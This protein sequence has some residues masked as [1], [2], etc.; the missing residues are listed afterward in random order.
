MEQA[1]A[2]ARA[3]A[4][5]GPQAPPPPDDPRTAVRNATRQAIQDAIRDMQG[6]PGIPTIGQPPRNSRPDV[7]QGAIQFASMFFIMIAVIALGVPIVRAL[8]RRFDRKTEN[9]KLGGA[10]MEHQLRQL[11]DSVDSMAIEIERI[12]ES[13]RFTSKLMAERAASVPLL[14]E[15]G[16]G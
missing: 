10:N 3:S 4:G 7:P 5:V 13:Q 15:K 2:P 8:A 11:Q 14:Q 16:R 1:P 9:M 12:S 6:Q